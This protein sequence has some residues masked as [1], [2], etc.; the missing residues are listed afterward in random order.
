MS[1][2]LKKAKAWT[3]LAFVKAMGIHRAPSKK[4][5]ELRVEQCRYKK[6]TPKLIQSEQQE[7]SDCRKALRSVPMNRER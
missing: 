7:A 6:N 5:R 4:V 1:K 2:I 3:A